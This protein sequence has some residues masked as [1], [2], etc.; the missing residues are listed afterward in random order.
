MNQLLI[1]VLLALFAYAQSLLSD[2]PDSLPACEAM[3]MLANSTLPASKDL[4]YI[5]RN[6]SYMNT[7]TLG[8][9]PRPALQCAVGVWEEFEADPVNMYPWGS[10]MELDQVRERASIAMSCGT[11]EL[12]LTPSTTVSLNMVG[13][14]LVTSGTLQKGANILVTDQEHGGGMAVWEHWQ[15]AGV[16]SSVDTVP[17]P[18]GVDATIDSVVTTFQRALQTAE[19]EDKLYTV[20]MVSHVLT[21]TGLRLP[22]PELA[23]LVHSHNPDALFVVDGAQAPGAIN[24][25]LTATGA[26]VYTVSAHKWLLAPTGSGLLYVRAGR[27]QAAVTPTYTDGGFSAYSVSSGTVPLQTI[28]GLG[29]AFDFFAAYGGLAAAEE[30]NMRL[31]EYSYNRLATLV[32]VLLSNPG[33]KDYTGLEIISPPAS[34]GVASPIIGMNLPPEVL[35]NSDAVSLLKSQYGVVVKLLPDYEG[36]NPFNVNAIRMSHHIFNCQT[37]VDKLLTGLTELLTKP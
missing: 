20:V 32:D 22:L 36:G 24:L 16:I 31:R 13:E 6:I 4:F 37:D 3:D 14:G 8:P 1:G 17:V 30:H 21:T 15:S 19:S 28:A 33:S 27:A 7:A 10:G 35:L 23:D 9:M 11:D 26:D 2:S 12:L 18:Y 25:N 5:K 29:Y 34:S